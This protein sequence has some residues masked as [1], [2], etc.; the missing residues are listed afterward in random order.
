[1]KALIAGRVDLV[2]M[3]GVFAFGCST[4]ARDESLAG[5]DLN[6]HGACS[7]PDGARSFAE[8]ATDPDHIDG[9]CV[10]EYSSADLGE[11]F[12]TIRDRRPLEDID[13]P[14]F[15]R[16]IPWLQV[17]NGCEERAPAAVFFLDQ[18]GFTA[19]YYARVKSKKGQSL[20]LATDNDPA[21]K[22]QW[23]HHVAPVVR[24]GS[25]LMVL[26][27][28]INAA[29]P[30][31]IADWIR[32]FNRGQQVDV[33][34]CRDIEVGDGCFAAAPVAPHAPP[35]P[36]GRDDVMHMR[37]QVEWRVQE[38]L[39]RDP[40]RVLGNCPPWLSCAVPEPVAD[41]TQAPRIRRFASDQFVTEVFAPIIYI[42]GD[43]F[44]PDVTTVRIQGN[45]IDELAPID[46]INRLR[47]LMVQ[48]Y[49]SGSYRVTAAN[50]IH[51]S[52]VA[53]LKIE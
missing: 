51:V 20:G 32:R 3:F 2:V 10:P 9:A 5:P 12:T 27:P 31:P 14:D 15:P 50:G 6:S 29:A 39:G 33:A 36:A 1:M 45:G 21:G 23:S 41:P 34:L 19:P 16:R 49:P 35:I 38:I 46:Q 47:I 8:Q 53:T 42:I 25:E 11:A 18:A 4:T 37:L 40:T 44:V 48:D 30:L 52:D 24:V 26:D 13:Q 7:L 28:A 22:V 43:N 17:D